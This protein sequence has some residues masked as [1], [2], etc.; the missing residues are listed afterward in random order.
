MSKSNPSRGTILRGT[1]IDEA[2]DRSREQLEQRAAE[3]AEI[4]GVSD[5]SFSAEDLRD[6][7]REIDGT[8][9]SAQD[10]AHDELSDTGLTRDPSEPPSGRGHQVEDVSDDDEQS[11]VERLARE[12]VDAAE[13]ETMLAE[14]RRHHS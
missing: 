12:G 10:V 1:R 13:R 8:T 7:R 11:D 4:R 2:S 6:A 14:R 9:L 5:G 3:L